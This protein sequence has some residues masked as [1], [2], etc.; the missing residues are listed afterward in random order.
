MSAISGVRLGLTVKIFGAMAA[1]VTVVL[2]GFLALATSG[3]NRTADEALA[4]ALANSREAARLFVQA[5]QAK[6]ASGAAAAVQ[7]PAFLAAIVS[8]DTPSVLDEAIQFQEI[9]G[10]GYTLITDRSRARRGTPWAGR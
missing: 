2:A 5:E 4:R 7:V 9:L 3:A 1:V 8:G 6:L 10:A